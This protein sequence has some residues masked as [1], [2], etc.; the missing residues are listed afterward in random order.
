M[1]GAA[2]AELVRDI[3]EHGLTEPIVRDADGRIVD[4]RNRYR[5]CAE[6]GVQPD[7]VVFTGEPWRY[8][9]STNLH[10]RHLTDNQRAVIAA[11]I[12]ERARG[13]RGPAR[14]PKDVPDGTSFDRPPSREEAADLL[15]VSLRQV[16]RARQVV[17]HGTESLQ[18][19]VESGTVPVTTAA[20]VAAE[21]PPTE[22]DAFV[23]AAN[24]AK[25]SPRPPVRDDQIPHRAS[26][27]A[28]PTAPRAQGRR[29]PL[30][31]DAVKAAQALDAAIRRWERLVGDDRW[32]DNRVRVTE[33][34]GW[35]LNRAA[36]VLTA[37]K[38]NRTP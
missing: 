23:A 17:K 6:A 25:A 4:G 7:Y 29:R 38:E 34:C 13:E 2:F 28:E 22:Q 35:A 36:D 31:E 20:R 32:A 27:T 24:E 9:V 10:R 37:I 33:T 14:D 19:A 8:V 5:A 3:A 1:A 11:K 26:P 18:A 15:N 12:A 30:T 16:S 21:L